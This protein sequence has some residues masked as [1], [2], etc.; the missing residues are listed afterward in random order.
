MTNARAIINQAARKIHVLGRGQVMDAD[1]Y[2]DAFEVLNTMLGSLS[3]NT[4][5][6]FNNSRETFPLT[7]A[8]SYTIGVGAV[9]DTVAPILIQSAYITIGTVDYPLRQMNADEYANVAFKTLS[10]I[11]DSFYYEKNTPTARIFIYPV[12]TSYTL[13][14]Y[15]LKPFTAFSN[16]TANYDLPPGAED[17]LVYN[18]AVRLAS[19][20]E[21]EASATVKQTAVQ[22]LRNVEAY[23]KRNNYPKSLIDIAGDSTVAGNILSGWYIR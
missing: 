12:G 18:L 14:L 1:E 20:Y 6:I 15:G 9:F 7:G 19:E 16:L 2:Q 17:M 3:T 22:T 5:L 23:N 21:K 11:P 13:T 4:G 10:G 8:Q